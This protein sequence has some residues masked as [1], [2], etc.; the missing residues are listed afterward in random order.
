MDI[1]PGE[2]C[3]LADAR[4]GL[5]RRIWPILPEHGQVGR[6]YADFPVGQLPA[7]EVAAPDPHSHGIERRIQP[8]R[9]FLR[10]HRRFATEELVYKVHKL[11][12]RLRPSLGNYADLTSCGPRV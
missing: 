8:R 4:G 3:Y 7:L 6:V 11:K 12:Y 9:D 1:N 10:S 5:G 2:D